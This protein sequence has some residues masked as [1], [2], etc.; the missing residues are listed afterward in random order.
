VDST[1]FAEIVFGRFR[2]E[3]IKDQLALAREDTK[4]CVCRRVPERPLS[5]THGAVAVNNVVEFG[6]NLERDPTAMARTP[7]A[8][9]HPASRP[10][11][12]VV[13]L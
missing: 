9:D 11:L 5:T 8:L 1:V 6:A 4:I 13:P 7:I 3:L 2:I 12:R 10:N